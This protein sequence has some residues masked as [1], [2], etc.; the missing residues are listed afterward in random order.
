[1]NPANKNSSVCISLMKVRLLHSHKPRESA[2][3]DLGTRR[4]SI[5]ISLVEIA[6]AIA[7]RKSPGRKLANSCMQVPV[8]ITELDL[9]DAVITSEL[10]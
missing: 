5:Q 1:M 7:R 2:Q 8:R 9:I 4:A 3:E 6:T 10:T